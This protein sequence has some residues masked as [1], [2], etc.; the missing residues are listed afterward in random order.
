ME[1]NKGLMTEFNSY[2]VENN[3]SPII[4]RGRG[5]FAVSPLVLFFLE[6][7]NQKL[8]T[9]LFSYIRKRGI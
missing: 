5:D 8:E 3:P 7:E 4:A 9:L 1:E 6:T 2:V